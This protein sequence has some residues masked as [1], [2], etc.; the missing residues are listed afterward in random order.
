MNI[1]EMAELATTIIE[2]NIG[3]INVDVR[4]IRYYETY[5]VMEKPPKKGRENDYGIEN[6][7]RLVAIKALQSR[8]ISLGQIK[9]ENVDVD[10]VLRSVG[11]DPLVVGAFIEREIE[12]S[13]EKPEREDDMS[14]K[15]QAEPKKEKKK[16]KEGGSP[17]ILPPEKDDNS[18][19]VEVTNQM[20]F[21]PMKDRLFV[22][23]SFAFVDGPDDE[24]SKLIYAKLH[25]QLKKSKKMKRAVIPVSGEVEL[26]GCVVKGGRGNRNQLGVLVPD[27]DS[28]REGDDVARVLV[29]EPES[30]GKSVQLDVK[31]NGAPLDV[32]NVP[33]DDN[34]C[35]IA[36]VPTLVAGK[37][38]VHVNGSGDC[39]FEASRYELDPLTISVTAS[40]KTP[41]G[42][43]IDLSAERFGKPMKGKAEVRLIDDGTPISEQVVEFKDGVV[44][45][46]WDDLGEGNASVMLTPADDKSLIA[47]APILGS[48]REERE[49]TTI[50]RMGRVM[51]ASL[52]ASKG[53]R[54][55]RG[56]YVSEES[57]T[58]APISLE[59]VFCDNGKLNLKF[60]ADASKVTV[61][62]S[63]PSSGEIEIYDVGDV[64][65]GSKRSIK[66]NSAFALV[67]VGAFVKDR[68]WEANATVINPS[69]GEFKLSMPGEGLFEPGDEMEIDL[70]SKE[71]CS[72]FLKVVDTRVRAMYE[73]VVAIA[74]KAKSWFSREML[75]LLTGNAWKPVIV[76]G[77]YRYMRGFTGP[78]GPT[79]WTGSSGAS[80]HGYPGGR[81][82]LSQARVISRR[83]AVPYDDAMTKGVAGSQGSS[84]DPS[85]HVSYHATPDS[86][87]LGTDDHKVYAASL[88]PPAA[89]AMGS[90]E[91]TSGGGI[92]LCDSIN[93]EMPEVAEM[94]S[95][96]SDADV[97]FCDLLRVP[98]S[99]RKVKI[100]LPD[101]IASYDV[102]AF[103]VSGNDWSEAEEKA[104][105]IKH[106]YIEPMIPAV[107]VPTDQ[108]RAVVVNGKDCEAIVTV[109]GEKVEITRFKTPDGASVM[110][111]WAALPGV[112]EVA[113]TY[114]G[115]SDRVSKIV[116]PPGEEIVLSQETHVMAKGETYELEED[117][118]S[119]YV[120]PGLEE[121]LETVVH[122]TV[123]YEHCCCEQT[124]AKIVAACVAATVGN[125]GDKAKAY[126]AIANGRA[127]LRSLY[128]GGA[129]NY[130]PGHGVNAWASDLAAR[131]V[132]QVDVKDA[133][134]DVAE[135]L[136]DIRKMGV[137]VVASASSSYQSDLEAAFA[138]G[139]FSSV[140][141]TDAMT[142]ASSVKGGSSMA[143]A[144]AAYAA[145]CLLRS[146]RIAPGIQVANEV[147][148]AVAPAKGGAMYGT[149]D[150]LGYLMMVMSLSDTGVIPASGGKVVVDGAK[151]DVVDATNDPATRIEATDNPVAI[152]INRVK[153]LRLDEETSEVPIEVKLVGAK[154]KKVKA[155]QMARLVVRTDGYK[156]G[157]VVVVRLP[158]GLSRVVGGGKQKKF[159]VDFEGKNEVSIDLVAHEA[160]EQQM[161]VVVR[162]MYDSSRIGSAG[163]IDVKVVA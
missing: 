132:A 54:K 70:T 97:V 117:A 103:F 41:E 53:A 111:T 73:P 113:A 21:M 86:T 85:Y 106:L 25:G 24:I 56:I 14:V 129:F 124:A 120:M 122:V 10:G 146:G 62:V 121:E 72:V 100:K 64:S 3:P 110:L 5:G 112:H 84:G 12:E 33:I 136:D 79:G 59:S 19:S 32:M 116:E 114:K 37:Y 145:S 99:G 135:A 68:P 156:A 76:D 45:S 128:N 31:L 109:N 138:K 90:E 87:F 8:G 158:Q 30:K 108:C 96:K 49:D 160:A 46:K 88:A 141:T 94:E 7:K 50:S 159:Q 51:T 95:R 148:K 77:M 47:S 16:E 23:S 65:K 36:R 80:G 152:R 55:E 157:D 15:G 104:V 20:T 91:L 143:I 105:A 42:I 63:D 142:A 22:G 11:I 149:N 13:R 74:S 48:R 57:V 1:K 43:E 150:M 102:K 127:R 58:N 39:S 52:M 78:T 89:N 82:R 9:K 2:E 101:R 107:A 134:K 126:K 34:G 131:R 35:G 92:F 153:K 154:G 29:F 162:N 38:E 147:A 27:K 137:S 151:K 67:S 40:R 44:T 163:L 93:V 60:S 115:H 71:P 81:R 140:S 75:G 17:L 18:L 4:T 66:V 155:G 133:P 61:A 139:D 161:G 69:R 130:Y 125:D 98:K 144:D 119:A 6:L 28:Y 123:N 83:G 26:L 118:L